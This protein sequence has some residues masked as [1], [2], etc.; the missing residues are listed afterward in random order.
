MKSRKILRLLVLPLATLII[1]GSSCNKDDDE[2]AKTKTE[3]LTSGA[4]KM[5]AHT[6]NPAQDLDGDGQSDD[7]D[8]FAT[9]DAC[10]KDDLT[11]FSTNGS[12]I[13]SEG[14]TKCDP[15]DPASYPFTWQ[16]SNNET[17]LSLLGE[18]FTLIELTS[19]TLKVS[20][21][22]SDAGSTY[23]ETLTFTH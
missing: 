3:L 14:A 18:D 22:Y 8:V 15:S 2:P 11:S 6:V 4:W 10:D 16:W 20:F 13:I 17:V 7:S 1:T 9:Y 12:G 21:S 23:T 5:S 19:S